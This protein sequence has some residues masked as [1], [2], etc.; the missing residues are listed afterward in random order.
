[1]KPIEHIELP[2]WEMLQEAAISPEA[3]NLE[4]LLDVLDESLPQLNTAMQLQVGGEAIAQIANLF[5]ERSALAFE[6]LEA[7]CSDEGPIMAEDAFDRYVRQTMEVDFEQ[8]IE[9]IAHL[10]RKVPEPQTHT[11]EAGSIVGELDRE[12]VLQRLDEQMRQHPELNEAEIFNQ[13]MAIAHDEDIPAWVRTITQW[14]DEHQVTM[15]PLIQ[16]QQATGMPLV[17]LWLALLLGGFTLQQQGEFYHTPT[18]WIQVD[19]K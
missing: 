17:Q 14:M 2:L 18:L 10:P 9:P 3:A 12:A 16:L 11:D 8:F 5:E 1:M 19:Q 6:A 15:I 7:R 4:Q 13:A